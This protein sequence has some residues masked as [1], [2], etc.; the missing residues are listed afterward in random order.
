MTPGDSV[1]ATIAF[2]DPWVEN[3]P[4]WI[5]E[6]LRTRYK[7]YKKKLSNYY[8]AMVYDSNNK[9]GVTVGGVSN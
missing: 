3:L 7:A 1:F 9:R 5:G 8:Q 6:H 4:S 2:V